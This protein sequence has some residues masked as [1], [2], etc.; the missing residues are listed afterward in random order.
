MNRLFSSP[1]PYMLLAMVIF[2][3]NYAV[4][5]AVV[6]EVPPY[7]LG[8]VRWAGA[9]L[10]L[11]PFT[12]RHIARDRGEVRRSLKLLL[13]CGFLMP[14]LGAG[15]AYVAL[16]D[17]IA[18]N[19]GIIQTSLP[20]LTVLIAWLVLGERIGRLQAVGAAIAIVGV[21]TI[22]ARGDPQALLALRF[23]WGDLVLVVSN[24][25]LASYAVAI[26]RMPR[27]LHPMTVL[28]VV[29]VVGGLVHLPFAAA[30][31]ASGETIRPTRG[32]ALALLF[33]ATLPSVVAIMFWN[34]GIARLGPSRAGMYMYL[35]PVVTA[36][37]GAAF[38]GEAIAA[39]HLVGGALIIIG[40]AASTAIGQAGR[41]RETP[42]D[43]PKPIS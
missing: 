16:I 25:A 35:V 34:N 43:K 28:T 39:Y 14:F 29:C 19:A 11:A 36:V 2:A 41:S 8:F 5:R 3:A 42:M 21:V 12:W 33:V 15:I 31:W 13:L 9:A 23:Q 37:L 1:H 10:I 38:L 20:V 6:G 24:L 30:E 18:V 17:T 40:V 22:V 32:A 27:G 7:T 26:K 4:G